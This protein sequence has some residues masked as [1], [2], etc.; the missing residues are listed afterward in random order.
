MQ[1]F[2]LCLAW[3]W[4]YDAA[5]VE[6]LACVFQKAGISLY[7]ITPANLDAT[8]QALEREE[9]HFK[10]FFD[11]ASD[12]DDGFIPLV[13]W[14]CQH[15][16][17]HINHHRLARRAWDKAA[18]H[19]QLTQA[20]LDAPYTIILP[21]YQEQPQVPELDLTPLGSC[22]AIKPS[23]GGS[24]LGVILEATDWEQ[25]LLARQQYSADPYLIQATVTPTWFDGHPAWFRVIYCVG[26]VFVSWWDPCTHVY[27]PVTFEERKRFNLEPLWEIP[28][29][30]ANLARLEL[31]SSEIAYAP[32]KRFKVI[33][34]LND[35][36]DLRLQ[37]ETVE[38]VPDITVSAIAQDIAL[39]VISAVAIS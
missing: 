30:I 17:L 25:V 11:R 8:L 20:G 19:R 28:L 31:F 23:H 36:I 21:S 15:V 22:F 3:N 35:P 39:Y 32:D 26:Q 38:G 34:Y 16:P 7:Q 9:L 33:D 27:T 29:R 18:M 1:N 37:S 4:P 5:F 14:A 24:G 13:E 10:A 2:D 6:R 12:G